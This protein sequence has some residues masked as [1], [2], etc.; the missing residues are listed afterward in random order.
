MAQFKKRTNFQRCDAFLQPNQKIIIIIFNSQLVSCWLSV[1]AT[2]MNKSVKT[3]TRNFIIRRFEGKNWATL[4]I[5]TFR[6]TEAKHITLYWSFFR[7][8]IE[9]GY[10]LIPMFSWLHASFF[11]PIVHIHS[12]ILVPPYGIFSGGYFIHP[13]ALT[14]SILCTIS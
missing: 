7:I 2:S 13:I 6:H 14:S 3:H 1:W 11:L 5:Y 4:L 8:W 10:Y 9:W 12:A